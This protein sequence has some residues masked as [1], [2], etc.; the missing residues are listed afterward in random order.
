MC[1]AAVAG[2]LL[3]VLIIAATKHLHSVTSVLLVNLA[4][5]DLLVGAAVMPFVAISLFFDAWHQT[6]GLCVFVGYTSTLYCSASVITLATIALDRYHAIIDCLSYS[7]QSTLRRTLAA[8]FWTW[9]Q[10]ALTSSPPVFGWGRFAYSPRTFCCAVD[11]SSSTGYAGF[12]ATS[13]FL[14]PGA[15]MLFCYVRI[16]QVARHH[17]RRIHH[18]E[19]QLKHNGNSH[20]PDDE[21]RPPGMEPTSNETQNSLELETTTGARSRRN[22][23]FARYNAPGR[24]YHGVF[25]ILL[26]IFAFFSCW[27]PIVTV[28]VIQALQYTGDDPDIELVPSGV[29]MLASLLSLA[30]SAV[31]PLLYALLSKRF[32]KALGTLR[33]RVH[34]RLSVRRAPRHTHALKSPRLGTSPQRVS[35]G[36]GVSPGWPQTSQS[37]SFSVF[38][39]ASG[40]EEARESDEYLSLRLTGANPRSFA[41]SDRLR[42]TPGKAIPAPAIPMIGAT[43]QPRV[44]PLTQTLMEAHSLPCQPMVT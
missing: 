35:R 44:D 39:I 38:S 15:V 18:L 6:S 23:M 9:L 12:W 10:A 17:A 43:T 11:W 2:N 26:V 13:S 29:V 33:Q 22:D 27:L 41:L 21:K 31:N 34:S 25:R 5:C 19:A 36:T 8:V 37:H 4:V 42:R 30:N 32:R 3:V 7:S 28:N 20:G 14:L 40:A 1:V 24:E 16:V